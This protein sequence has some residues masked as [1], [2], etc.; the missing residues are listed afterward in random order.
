[1]RIGLGGLGG[2]GGSDPRILPL[3]LLHPARS[4]PMHVRDADPS[5][6]DPLSSIWYH[7]WRDAHAE[8]LPAELG[9]DRSQERLRARLVDGL[10]SVRV[11][12]AIGA[13][14]G[15]TWIK[16]DQLNQLYVA[17]EARGAGVAASLVADAEA[18]M[19]AAGVRT[20]WLSCAIG[21]TRAARFYEKNGWRRVGINVERLS[22]ASG[23][24]DLEV[25]RYEKVLE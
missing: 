18:R 14:L 5:D 7:G 21:N 10:S 8:L 24:L 11:A 13:P 2:S 1:M 17:P 25:W 22:M 12:G 20:A 16:D 9:Q 4:I 15:F 23:E 3:V 19:R 6:I